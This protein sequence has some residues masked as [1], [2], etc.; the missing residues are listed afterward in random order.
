MIF[1]AF[2][3]SIELEWIFQFAMLDN[4]MVLFMAI[5]HLQVWLSGASPIFMDSTV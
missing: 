1:P 3:T 5:V 4:Q 2:E